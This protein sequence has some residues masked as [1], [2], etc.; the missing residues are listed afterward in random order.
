MIHRLTEEGLPA[1][2]EGTASYL[3]DVGAIATLVLAVVSTH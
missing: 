3:R 2:N 1:D